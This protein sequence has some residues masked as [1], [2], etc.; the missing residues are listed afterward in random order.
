MRAR[1]ATA[2]VASSSVHARIGLLIVTAALEL[3][4]LPTASRAQSPGALTGAQTLREPLPYWA[5]VVDQ[6]PTN[7]AAQATPDDTPRHVPGST[8]AFTLTQ[9]RDLFAAPDWHPGAHPAMP[10]IVAHGRAP[11]VF[12]CGYCH[13]PNGQGRPENS[14]LA[15]LSVRYI[16][17]QMAAFKSG[18]RRS[19]EPRHK[20]GALMTA[21]AGK[22]GDQEA[23]IAAEY[24]SALKPLKW[25]RVVETETVPVTRVAGW[26]LV[27]SESA[28][29]EAIGERIIE[30]P[31][32]LERTELRDD[33]SGFVAYVP[34]GSVHNGAV[35]AAT[36]GDGKTLPCATCHGPQLKGLVDVPA[37]AGRSPSYLVRQMVDIRNGARS[38]PTVELM[39]AVVEKLT[40]EDMLALAAYAASLSP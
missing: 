25:I 40:I 31:E 28:A 1:C 15:G 22:V 8:A 19:S 4:A 12:A 9:I 6:A 13:L 33:A 3:C 39:R 10:E 11:E 14:R 18:L 27:A 38:G 16:V 23:Q 36:G 5:F 30:T 24:F 34:R 2:C 32:N 26:M 17:G 35:L 7:P 20:P 37:L 21:L 29:T